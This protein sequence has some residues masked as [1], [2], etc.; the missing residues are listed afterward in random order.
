MLSFFDSKNLMKHINGTAIKP[1]IPPAFP[2]HYTP[3]DEEE[4]RYDKAEERL[5]KY[6]ARESM[7]KS[8]VVISV[9]ESL[10][11][12][13]QKKGTAKDLWDALTDEMTKKPKMVVT[14]LSVLQRM[15]VVESCRV[16]LSR[17]KIS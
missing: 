5:E 2:A 12:M 8:Q 17:N 11:L 14:I 15:C 9:S 1:P 3:T 4:A 13:L 16:E 10:A 6:M 7:V